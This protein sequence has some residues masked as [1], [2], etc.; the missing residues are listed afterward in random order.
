M[1]RGFEMRIYDVASHTSKALIRGVSLGGAR[2]DIGGASRPR[3]GNRVRR[4]G[5]R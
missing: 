2:V 3:G 4:R 5:R 1:K